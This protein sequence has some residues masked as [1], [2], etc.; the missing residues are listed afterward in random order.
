MT[1]SLQGEDRAAGNL[2]AMQIKVH[3][4]CAVRA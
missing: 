1:T 3:G 2:I 4:M